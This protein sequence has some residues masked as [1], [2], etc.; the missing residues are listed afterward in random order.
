MILSDDAGYN[1]FGFTSALNNGNTDFQTPNLDAL[2][3]Q[4]VIGTKFYS[5][6]SICAPSRAG[7]LTGQYQQRYGFE[8]NTPSGNDPVATYGTA[9]LSAAQTTVAQ[10]L[11]QLGYSTGAIGKWHLGYTDGLNLPADKGFDEFY[12][13]WGADRDYFHSCC[14]ARDMRRG[15]TDIESTWQ[16]EGDATQYDPVNGR[17]STDAFGEESVDF[18]NRHS[19]DGKPFFLYLAFNAEHTPYAA[20]QSDLDHFANIEDPTKRT[21]AGIVYAMDRAIGNVV[22]ALHSNG[23]D[24]NTILVFTNDNGGLVGTNDNYPYY[25][26]KASQAEG[27]IRE[28]FIIKAPG[29]QPG[30]YGG[31]LTALDLAPTFVSAAGGNVSQRPSDGFNVM[32]LVSGAQTND[33]HQAIIWRN[34]YFWAVAKGDWKLTSKTQFSTNRNFPSSPLFNLS[35]DPQEQTDLSQQHPEIVA[36]LLH[37][38]T[39]WEAQMQKPRWGAGTENQFDGFVFQGAPGFTMQWSTS[40]AWRQ[41]GTLQPVTLHPVDSYANA[42]LEFQ[43]MDGGNYTASNDMTRMSG[44][45]FMLNQLR[46]AGTFQGN[47][48]RNGTI[49]GAELLLV[50]SLDGH[51]PKIRLDAI[52][53]STTATFNFAINNPLQLLDD[54]EITGDGTQNLVIGGGISD[55]THPCNVTKTGLS[56]VTLTGNN[57][58]AGTLRINAGKLRIQ[59]PAA[60]VSGA[61]AIVIGADGDLTLDGGTIDVPLLDNSAGGAFHFLSG[62]LQVDQVIGDLVDSGASI[63]VSQVSGNLD[64]ADGNL[65]SG[66]GPHKKKV[67]GNFSQRN[68][69]LHVSLG[70]VVPG[71]Y[72]QNAI[73]GAASLG[74]TLDIQPLVGFVPSPGQS[75]QFLTAAGGVYGTFSRVLFPTYAGI[76]WHLEYEP[77]SVNIVIDSS[78]TP[79]LLGDYNH[80]GIVD[81]ADYTV[82]RDT[83]G[84]M[85][86]LAADGN[87]DGVVDQAD[88]EL[89]RMHFGETS[90]SSV[91]GESIAAPEPE[92]CFLAMASLL[93]IPFL[94][95]R[96]SCRHQLGPL[97]GA[98]RSLL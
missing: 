10:D 4:S 25:G 33:P 84:S 59:G 38:L 40:G 5:T 78:A 3:Q 43:T 56:Q 20:K 45:A 51:L 72:D 35:T 1:E 66:R 18:I 55:Y 65:T 76:Q 17:Y 32:P 29:L 23:V 53:S 70:G 2:A 42:T 54:L 88:M 87:G 95:R 26:G 37:E 46:L 16:T 12:G 77:E 74:G 75:F 60:A 6:D 36:D 30:V 41:T 28:P 82:W 71:S 34:F 8:Q 64:N 7:L 81:A 83:V 67:H 62:S 9:G 79:T 39:Y 50:K 92:S 19:N 89:W 13:F 90:G 97:V 47:V 94:Q 69:T 80:N 44:L 15:T 57:T 31:P 86:R 85:T 96:F 58:F 73:D 21:Q 98:N 11:K 14:E 24:Q 49:D 68:G 93:G 63:S 48:D 91:T 27:G 52:S 22:D 61:A